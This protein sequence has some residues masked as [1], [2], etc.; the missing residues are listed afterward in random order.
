M[1]SI[2]IPSTISIYISSN[3][4]KIEGPLGTF[5]K[6]RGA[7]KFSLLSTPEGSRLFVIGSTPKEESIILAQ[8]IT[9][10]IGLTL[11]FRKRLRLRG[12]G[13]RGTIQK[14]IVEKNRIIAGKRL[15]FPKHRLRKENNSNFSNKLQDILVLKLGYSHDT[16]YPLSISQNN[17]ID[18][19][20]SRLEG[21]TKG[22]VISIKGSNLREIS[23]IAQ[24]IVAFRY[25]DVYKGK[26]IHY[27]KQILSLK[28]GK[29]QS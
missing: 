8:I 18:V 17:N 1:L 16:A 14:S 10:I 12:I 19:A 5:I 29:R 9:Q 21:R 24:G 28:K 23:S 15:I 25:P 7:F 4:I 22:T 26:G 27:D 6:K 2:P 20:V 13:F 11:G 3:H